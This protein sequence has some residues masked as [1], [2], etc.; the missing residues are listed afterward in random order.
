[1]L[2]HW[3]HSR[4]PYWP[5]CGEDSRESS[6]IAWCLA[7]LQQ[8]PTRSHS[9]RRCTWLELCWIPGTWCTGLMSTSLPKVPTHQLQLPRLSDMNWRIPWQVWRMEWKNRIHL[10]NKVALEPKACVHSPPRH[11]PS[12]VVL[13]F[14]MIQDSGFHCNLWYS[15]GSW[16]L[17][18]GSS[19]AMQQWWFA[20]CYHSS[21]W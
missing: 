14:L 13:Q 11:V 20:G 18:V 4:R 16:V 15:L 19:M 7:M 2:S 6:W 17:Q 21:L 9:G 12:E 3:G 5:L 10:I 1:M 8:V